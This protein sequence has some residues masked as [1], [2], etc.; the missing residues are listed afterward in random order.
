MSKTALVTGMDSSAIAVGICESLLRS[1]FKVFA[2]SEG[3]YDAGKEE[4]EQFD[5][6]HTEFTPVSFESVDFTSEASIAELISRLESEIFDVIVNC[7]GT[8]AFADDGSL[9][10]ES[11]DFSFKEFNRVLQYNVT[12]IAAVCLGLKESVKPGGVIINVTSVA[13]QEG[14][15][16]TISYNAS[17]AAV[18][19]L[20]KSLANVLGPSKGIRVNGIAPGWIPPNAGAAAGGVVALGNALTPS[21]VIGTPDDVAKAV[22][23]LIDAPFQNGSILRVDG[24]VSAS[25]LPYMMESLELQGFPVSDAIDSLATLVR[26]AKEDMSKPRPS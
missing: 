16:A 19:N 22:A 25:Y 11:A 14:A 13:G 10:D 7:A 26:T 5:G 1:S 9:R 21:Q 15:F 23:F 12:S 20:T 24:G 2:T 17:K 6:A 8:I 18:D 3:K 4:R